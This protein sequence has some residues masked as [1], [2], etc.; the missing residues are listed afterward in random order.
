LQAVSGIGFRR[1]SAAA[2]GLAAPLIRGVIRPEP[3]FRI[4]DSDDV[5]G[6]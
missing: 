6:P 2:K 5:V 1:F 3:I 4:S